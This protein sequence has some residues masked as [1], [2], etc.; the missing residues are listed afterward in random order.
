M[1]FGLQAL[2][3]DEA[4]K[5]IVLISKPPAKAVAE[6]ILELAQAA[7]KPVVVN[8]LGAKPED[9]TRS[10]VMAA[11][12][13]A[14]AADLAVAMLR[15]TELHQHSSYPDAAQLNILQ[16]ASATLPA[17]RRFI[18]G[19]FAGGTFCYEAQLLCQQQGI[20]ASSNTPVTGNSKLA[21]IWKSSEHTLIDM[22]DDDFTRGKPHPMIDPTLRNQ[23]IHAELIDPTTAVVLFDLVLGYGAS[24]DPASGLLEL[25]AQ[26][27]QQHMPLLIAHVCGTEADPQVRSRQID[28][29][30]QAGVIVADCNAQAAAWASI[31]AQIQAQKNGVSA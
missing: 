13:L 16:Q 28:S 5:V 7:G 12:T 15:K 22:G 27:N 11:T 6:S 20:S 18:R 31:V 26:T 3:E 29:L 25:L 30:R 2:A 21:D 24:E 1:L 10:G 17:G 9:I 14:N 8:F 19:V 4:T 23:R